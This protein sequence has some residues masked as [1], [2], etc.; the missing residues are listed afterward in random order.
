MK[1]FIFIASLIFLSN[2]IL[3]QNLASK[4]KVHNSGFQNELKKVSDSTFE[5]SAEQL[6]GEQI[7]ILEKRLEQANET[8]ENLNALFSSAGTF[9]GI[10]L[11]IF[12]TVIPLLGY[13]FVIRPY[14]RLRKKINKGIEKY[15]LKDRI[16]RIDQAIT[17][18][19]SRDRILLKKGFTILE[20]GEPNEFTKKQVL[21]LIRLIQKGSHLSAE[22]KIILGHLLIHQDLNI[23]REFYQ[24]ELLSQEH[25]YHLRYVAILY[26]IQPAIN[27]FNRIKSALIKIISKKLLFKDIVLALVTNNKQSI[28]DLLGNQDITELMYNSMRTEGER[29]SYAGIE[30]RDTIR[31]ERNSLLSEDEYKDTVFFKTLSPNP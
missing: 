27:D 23:I 22:E 1:T 31:N 9:L 30:I 6:S 14:N 11:T 20:L 18:L 10:M 13:L 21:M 15:I 8:I 3:C 5:K 4:K 29:R 12:A 2:T 7:A 28:L 24:E 25:E 16:R 19:H 17:D 26:F